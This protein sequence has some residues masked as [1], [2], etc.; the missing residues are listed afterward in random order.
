RRRHTIFSRD[1]SSD[2]WSSDLSAAR[3]APVG[4]QPAGVGPPSSGASFQNVSFQS[5]VMDMRV[6]SDTTTATAA[7]T[8]ASAS[9]LAWRSA[10]RSEERR[11][12]D[13][14]RYGTLP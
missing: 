5:L 10:S 6:K 13:E 14:G 12:G 7:I 4:G 1:W 2:V 8:Y 11:V 3:P 9:R